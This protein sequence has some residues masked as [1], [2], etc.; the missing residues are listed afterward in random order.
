MIIEFSVKNYRSIKE[1]QTISFL[2]TGLKSPEQYADIDA[3]NIEEENNIRF[4]KTI[5]I[6]GA[7]ASGKSNI[8]KALDVFIKAISGEPSSVS[9]LDSLCDPYLYQENSENSESFFQIVF[10][11]KNKKY[12]YG[13]TAKSILSKRDESSDY[14]ISK[15]IIASEWLF[16]PKLKNSTEL[17]IRT[18]MDVTNNLPESENIPAIPYD[19]NLFLTH[20]A[21]FGENLCKEIRDFFRFNTYSNMKGGIESF[22]WLST[23]FLEP[24][25]YKEQFLNLLSSFGLN[26]QNIEIKKD[27]NN[28]K[29]IDLDQDQV[30]LYKKWGDNLENP[31]INLNLAKTESK[32]T[33]KLFDLAGVL[34]TLPHLAGGRLMIIDEIDSN[35][36]PMLL[37]KLINLFNDKSYNQNHSQ[38]IFASHDTNL[39]SPSIMRR[40]QFYFTEKASD[41]TSTKLYS[42]ADL[43]G[44]RNDADF[45]KQYLMGFFGAL[46]ILGQYLDKED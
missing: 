5:G 20:A 31:E 4:L 14:L 29:K 16:G 15:G 43:K 9:N 36:H 44:I 1:L 11:L 23:L 26:Y 41:G 32:G 2:A 12:R 10:T 7:N 42:I 38:L 22:R 30:I 6:Y 18:G 39:L 28:L 24:L 33:Q 8:I 17:F 27:P 46:P 19:H 35:F 40:D 21:A 34:L 25:S 13:L 3:N 45:A 37:L